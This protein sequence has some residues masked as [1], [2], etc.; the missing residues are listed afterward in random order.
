MHQK[1]IL[2]DKNSAD[3]I[4][5]SYYPAWECQ[6][7]SLLRELYIKTYEELYPNKIHIEV[8]HAGLEC[9]ILLE[10]FS[11]I[12]AISIGSDIWDV[13]SVAECFSKSSFERIWNV[14][15]K[16]LLTLCGK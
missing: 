12:D 6:K 9:G 8:I 11:A 16:I 13:H 14:I 3:V 7:H 2:A 5:N 10:K 4:F 15:Q 1:Q